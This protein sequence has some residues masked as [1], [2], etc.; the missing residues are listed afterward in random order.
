VTT[1]TSFSGDHEFLSNFYPS[2]FTMLYT[3]P[4]SMF[5]MDMVPIDHPT[6][7]HFFQAE[8]TSDIAEKR[9]I[10][11]ASTPGLAKRL[12]RKV[13]LRA[14][15]DSYRFTAMSQGIATKFRVDSELAAQLLETGDTYLVEGNTWGDYT[16]GKVNGLG[17]NWLG[18]ILMARRVELRHLT[19]L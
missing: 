19:S 9:K 11:A 18:V 4:D 13:Q 14:D 16:W 6:V 5:P 12:G 7:E 8:K 3:D 1:I 10:A 17:E 2:P 15:W